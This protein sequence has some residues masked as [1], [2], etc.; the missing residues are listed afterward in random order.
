M[1]LMFITPRITGGGAE[2]VITAL[3]SRFVVENEV[4]LVSMLPP[5][6]NSYPVSENVRQL[7]LYEEC[8]P[9]DDST[10]VTCP[11]LQ[12]AQQRNIYFSQYSG[13]TPYTF[14]SV[15][16]T[17]IQRVKGKLKRLI[18]II[19]R[20]SKIG[21]RYLEERTK[22]LAESTYMQ[23]MSEKLEACKRAYGI[24]CS[25]SFLNPANFLN[26]K[27]SAGIPTI[28]SIR[29]C[30]EGPFVSPELKTRIG[31]QELLYSCNKADRIIAVSKETAHGLKKNCHASDKKTFAIYNPCDIDT[32]LALKNKPPDDPEILEKIEKKGFVFISVGR[33]VMKKGQWHMIRAFQLVHEKHPEAI[34]LILGKRGEQNAEQLI[35]NTIHLLGLEKSVLLA[36]FHENPFSYLSKADAFV[37]SSF[38]EGFPNAITEAMAVGLPIISTDCRSGPREILAP[39]TDYLKKTKTID[40]AEYGI[41]VPECSGSTVID[42][43]P[44]QNEILMAD[45]M[46]RM[47]EDT[48]LREYYSAKSRER[49][50]AFSTE[51]NLQQ[52]ITLINEVIN[53]KKENSCQSIYRY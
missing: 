51:A 21:R 25:I 39:S 53:E 8:E 18:G 20:H 35:E 14:I 17:V 49:A 9:K 32:I 48:K 24:D 7:K 5:E 16:Q 22:A 4:Y 38:N 13:K 28:I 31:R 40:Y 42:R 30:V 34:L 2:R 50:K 45:A 52:W 47:I 3:A 29:S 1:R 43:G 27:S 6:G 19:L 33:V 23:K 44:E 12:T 36:G 15:F 41:L 10:S 11:V 26:T 37:F 46:I